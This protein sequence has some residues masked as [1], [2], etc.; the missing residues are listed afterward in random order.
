MIQQQELVEKVYELLAENR[1]AV[2][3]PMVSGP[4]GPCCVGC[5]TVEAFRLLASSRADAHT[6]D[7][8]EAQMLVLAAVS[9]VSYELEHAQ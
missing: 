8:F 6:W 7:S 5:T 9:Q 4:C 2:I 3:S 1:A